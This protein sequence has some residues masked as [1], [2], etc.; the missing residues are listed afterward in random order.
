MLNVLQ[1]SAEISV[2]IVYTVVICCLL[3]SFNICFSLAGGNNPLDDLIGD[4]LNST[5]SSNLLGGFE[6]NLTTVPQSQQMQRHLMINPSTSVH[7]LQP[8]AAGM[9]S[10]G[11]VPH[12]V[13]HPQ[14]TMH[15]GL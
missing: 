7:S 5:D 3:L 1:L 14:V 9:G 11:M 2:E 6:L 12:G 13:T 10:P 4:I 15:P 8:T